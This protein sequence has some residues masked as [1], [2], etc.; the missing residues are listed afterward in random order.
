MKTYQQLADSDAM[1]AAAKE[2]R[3]PF[4]KA[5]EEAKPLL[6]VVVLGTIELTSQRTD[7]GKRIYTLGAG[8]LR[9]TNAAL[10]SWCEYTPEFGG[11]VDRF[12]D[13]ATVTVYTD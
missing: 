4:V 1:Y 10:L 13:R 5:T 12:A 9:Y 6:D 11:F 7:C 2:S 3:A 8:A